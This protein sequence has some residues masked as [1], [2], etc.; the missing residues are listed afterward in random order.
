M[1][2]IRNIYCVGRNYRLHAAEL[3][4]DVP[5]KPM[6]FAKPTHALALTNGQEIALP[7]TRGELHYEAEIVVHIAR[8]YEPG[9]A[10]EQVIDKVALGIDLTLRDVQSELKSAGHPWLLAK[11]FKNSAILTPFQPFSGQSALQQADFSLH[12]N[13]EQVQ[14]GNIGDV[15]FDLETILAYIEEH[16]GLGAGDIIYTGTPA[17]VGPVADGDVL[18][19]KWGDEEWGQF[20]A[21]L[22]G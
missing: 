21:R 20:T 1:E 17:G 8:P 6:I 3:G 5:K 22:K 4:N 12:K 13:G 15:I 9:C 19:L 7:G 16:F 2:Q 14:R 18:T 11:G 10:L